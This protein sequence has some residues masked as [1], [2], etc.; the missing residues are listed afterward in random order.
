MSKRAGIYAR[1][2]TTDQ[3]DNGTSLT[4]QE[5]YARDFARACG[6]QVAD[7]DSIKEDKSG[8]IIERP[9]L[10]ELRAKMRKGEIDVLVCYAL[11][12][13]SRNQVHQTV[14]FYE[15]E[16]L[17][18]TIEFVT[19]K[20][21]DTPEGHMM[22]SVLG[23]MAEKE[24]EKILERTTRGTRARAESGRITHPVR[25]KY[26]YDFDAGRGRYVV[27]EEAAQV[28]RRIFT[29]VAEE[30][31]T[32]KQ[33]SDRLNGEGVASRGAYQQSKGYGLNTK[34]APYWYSAIIH[35]I[36]RE[37]IYKGV[38]KLYSIKGLKKRIADPLTGVVR[39]Y[40][41]AIRGLTEGTV[42]IPCPALVDE[43]LW[44]K[45]QT[46]LSDNR[47]VR[48]TMYGDN[49][50][51]AM[52]RGGFA[53]CGYCGA[54]MVIATRAREKGE[55]AS[56]TKIYRCGTYANNTLRFVGDCR[57]KGF[58]IRA[59]LIDEAVWEDITVFVQ[60]A[61]SFLDMY[62]SMVSNQDELKKQ[63]QSTLDSLN[64]TL[65]RE[66]R[67][68]SSWL[69]AIGNTEEATT[70]KELTQS[71][72]RSNLLIKATEAELA[73]KQDSVRAMD[74][75]K[76]QLKK[77]AE[78]LDMARS[79]MELASPDER[80]AFLRAVGARVRCFRVNDVD[81]GRY[82]LSLEFGGIISTASPRCL[83]TNDALPR[84]RLI[85]LRGYWKLQRE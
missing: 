67:K 60:K 15:A 44:D 3:A 1:V 46:A 7:E 30:R 85:G 43:A 19:E 63:A 70:I 65:L 29:L 55:G 2:S 16:Q 20:L 68:K 5:R 27:D 11:D 34:V 33:V 52:L 9:G 51:V 39:V 75:S 42:D 36:I 8:Y 57:G 14:L 6:Y 28:V 73:S 13:L 26:G 25:P 74:Q 66:Q 64:A 83:Y 82:E 41:S 23:Y 49:I 79:T 18:C 61:T 21:D 80:R 62:E 54:S 32:C 50:E 22:R 53:T 35:Q 59:H 76:D 40:R 47:K 58:S 4:T 69:V 72:E 38:L 78:Y 12:R 84:I 31:L 37:P 24:R 71:I 48:T 77:V 45:A 17:G 81:N 56:D 10:D